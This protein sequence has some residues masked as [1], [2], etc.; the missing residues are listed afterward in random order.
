MV[1]FDILDKKRR[2]LLSR[3][4]FLKTHNFYLAG[5]TAL[6][7]QLAHRVSVDFDFYRKQ[8]F[9]SQ[10]IFQEFQEHFGRDDLVQIH[11]DKG[12][13]SLSINN[14]ELSF[15]L[16]KYPLVKPLIK[17]EYVNLASPE[18]IGAMKI[19]AISQRGLRRDFIDIYFL[20]QKFT[21]NKLLNVAE[22]KYKGF[23]K[24][25][26][27]RGLIYFK[28][29]DKDRGARVKLLKFVP[30]ARVKKETIKI[31]KDFKKSNLE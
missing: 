30:W 26:A 13:L 4:A 25:L 19:I 9:D 14:I 22:K 17:T 27:L 8:E 10:K 31:I 15:F 21:L 18:D 16:Y 20:L 29:A 5:G 6:A 12:F 11:I 24:Y 7:L 28:D 3:L 1:N 23:N 2:T